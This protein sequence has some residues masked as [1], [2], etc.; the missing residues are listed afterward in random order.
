MKP[1]TRILAILAILTIGIPALYYNNAE[2]L[3][4][5]VTGTERINNSDGGYYLVYTTRGTTTETFKNTD[6]TL[7]LKWDSSDFQGK[8]RPS[9]AVLYTIKVNDWRIPMLSK[10]RNIVAIESITPAS[11]PVAAQ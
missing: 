4:V 6:A 5:E 2:T 1:L 9:R 8:L 10:Y 11:N 3:Q 7:Y